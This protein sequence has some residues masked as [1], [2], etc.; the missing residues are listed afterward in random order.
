IAIMQHPSTH[1]FLTHCGD[2]SLM[3]AVQAELP[4]AGI[5]FFAD[6]GDVC[7]RM[8]EAG[9]GRYVGHKHTFTADELES[10]LVDVATSKRYKERIRDIH[11]ISKLYGGVNRAA[12]IIEERMSN[13]LLRPDAFTE[14]CGYLTEW[15]GQP[16]SNALVQ[17]YDFLLIYFALIGLVC[18]GCVR[19][20]RRCI[21]SHTRDNADNAQVY[22]GKSPSVKVVR[23]SKITD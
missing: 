22:Q 5:P 3:E 12:D 21:G 11:S 20:V 7:Q 23:R 16:K 14:S 13:D 17:E 19:C 4:L 8:D 15:S 10:I 6:Q 2:T 9:I 1:V 18:Y